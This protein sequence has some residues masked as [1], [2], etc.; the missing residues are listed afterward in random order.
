MKNLIVI[1]NN[2]HHEFDSLEEL[3]TFILGKEYFELEEKEKF[4]ERYRR[5]F[6]ICKFSNDMPM[7]HTKM[8]KLIEKYQVSEEPYDI[9]VSFIIDDEFTYILSLCK[10]NQILLLENIDSSI[11]TKCVDKSKIEDNYIVVNSHVDKILKD[12]FK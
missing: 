11:F 9:Y 5:A 1:S 2:K 10:T 8:G 7:V 3:K 12:M 4:L 6:A